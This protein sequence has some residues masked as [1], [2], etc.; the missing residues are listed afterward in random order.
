MFLVECQS[1]NESLVTI[2]EDNVQKICKKIND[3]VF[4][5]MAGQVNLEVRAMLTKFTEKADNSRVL[6]DFEGQ[7]ND[8]KDNKRHEMTNSYYDLIEWMIMLYENYQYTVIDDMYKFIEI[9][10]RQTNKVNQAIET[11]SEQLEK[12][13]KEIEGKLITD[14]KTFK[15][16]LNAV[17]TEVE[18]FKQKST[19]QLDKYNEAVVTVQ[20]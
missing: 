13:R 19:K 11:Q 17:K 10:Y 7:L 4:T 1:L 3:Y 12:Q 2:C 16:E 8:Y 9:A 15:E 6:V 18:S 5:E 20:E 14:T